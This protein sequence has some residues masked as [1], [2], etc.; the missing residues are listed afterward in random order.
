MTKFDNG[1]N[2]D[3]M[4]MEDILASIRKYVS[5]DE[6]KRG[7]SQKGDLGNNAYRGA[8]ADSI[9]PDIVVKLEENQ[10]VEEEEEVPKGGHN[11]YEIPDE[12]LHR[13]E[14]G[15]PFNRL[16][17]VLKSHPKTS[18]KAADKTKTVTVDNFLRELA[19]SMI[20]EWIDNNLEKMVIYIV[21]REIEKIKNQTS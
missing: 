8:S 11:F 12:F 14:G 20:E 3:D 7:Q 4:S 15:N 9:S 17:S 21:E 13:K 16:S 10:I 2:Q 6:A 1:G 5:D 18:K 19:T